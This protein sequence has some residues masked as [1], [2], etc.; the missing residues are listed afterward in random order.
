MVIDCD[1]ATMCFHDFTHDGKT[2]AGALTSRIFTAPKTC[3][4]ALPIFRRD[5]GAFVSYMDATIG[6]GAYSHLGRRRGVCDSVLD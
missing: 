4:D 3:E 6:I 5:A 1:A 2:E